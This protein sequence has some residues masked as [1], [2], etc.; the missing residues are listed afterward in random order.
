MIFSDELHFC[1]ICRDF[2]PYIPAVRGA[3]CSECGRLFNEADE[4][5]YRRFR[6]WA[7]P[8]RE[9]VGAWFPAAFG[10]W[11]AATGQAG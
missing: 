8:E 9:G 6:R 4:I 1:P 11:Q 3:C 2:V 10:P 7:Y 5:A